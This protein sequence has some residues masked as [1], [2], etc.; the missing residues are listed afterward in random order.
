MSKGHALYERCEVCDAT[1]K[2]LREIARNSGPP[3]PVGSE[4]PACRNGY[5]E[6]GMTDT[7][8]VAA[9]D[10]RDTLLEFV[11]RVASATGLYA[12]E[13]VTTE[14]RK[15]AEGKSSRVEEIRIRRGEPRWKREECQP[16][17]TDQANSGNSD[18]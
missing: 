5:H 2:T 14:A 1:R 7:Q 8:L 4:C 11:G 17:R 13:T 15:L 6:I 18:G 16:V 10:E 9:L 3:L 12:H